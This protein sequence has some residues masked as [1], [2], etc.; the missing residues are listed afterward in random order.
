MLSTFLF[1]IGSYFIT[2]FFTFKAQ[3]ISTPAFK[4]RYIL[5]IYMLGA[6]RSSAFLHVSIYL[7]SY[8]L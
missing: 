2:T 8:I 4:Y 6:Y 3:C 1:Y 5:G 7:T